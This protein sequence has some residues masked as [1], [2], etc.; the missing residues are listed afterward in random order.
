MYVTP[1]LSREDCSDTLSAIMKDVLVYK[2]IIARVNLA[3]IMVPFVD[4]IEVFQVFLGRLDTHTIQSTTAMTEITIK[5]PIELLSTIS[6]AI[7][8]ANLG[9]LSEHSPFLRFYTYQLNTQCRETLKEALGRKRYY[10]D[11]VD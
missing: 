11:W 1:G 2:G 5:V 4:L 8:Q 10:K 3:R 7:Q 6:L 9:R